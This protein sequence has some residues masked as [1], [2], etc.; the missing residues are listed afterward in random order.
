MISY[1]LCRCIFSQVTA[2]LDWIANQ[3]NSWNK[4]GCT[5]SKGITTQSFRTLFIWENLWNI[6]IISWKLK[7]NDLINFFNYNFYFCPGDM[8]CHFYWK[9]TERNGQNGRQSPE[10]RKQ[11]GQNRV[12]AKELLPRSEPPWNPKDFLSRR[13]SRFE[14]HVW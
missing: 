10:I 1:S 12:G 7:V 9:K 5:K 13:C 2:I 8:F 14:C 11:N 4:R 3:G 6:I